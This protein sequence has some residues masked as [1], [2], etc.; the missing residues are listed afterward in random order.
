M[1]DDDGRTYGMWVGPDE[2]E[3]IEE[4]DRLHNTG[5]GTYSRSEQMK[6]ALRLMNAVTETKHRIG[7]DLEGHMLRAWVKQSMLDQARREAA[8]DATE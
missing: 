2:A 3:L 7:Y 5:D 1:S 8:N 4:F 6:E